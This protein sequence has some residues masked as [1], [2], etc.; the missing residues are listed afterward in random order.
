MTAYIIRVRP[1]PFTPASE[2]YLETWSQ[3]GWSHSKTVDRQRAFQFDSMSVAT[4]VGIGL[5]LDQDMVI[6]PVD[7]GQWQLDLRPA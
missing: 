5:G 6:I 3:N 2:Y 4:C 7:N 1:Q